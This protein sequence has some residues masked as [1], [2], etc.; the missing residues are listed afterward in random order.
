MLKRLL[1]PLGLLLSLVTPI[2]VS[3]AVAAQ[4]TKT[5]PATCNNFYQGNTPP[6]AVSAAVPDRVILCE[7]FYATAYSTRLHN[8]IW[9]SY[10]LTKA[11]SLG[12]DDFKRC[13]SSFRPDPQLT[14]DQQGNDNDYAHTNFDR[15]HLVPADDAETRDDQTH[16]FIVTNITPQPHKFNDG[17]WG[18]LEASL[19]MLVRDVDV[20]FV[21][22]G[23]VFRANPPTMTSTVRPR[24]SGDPSRI[25]IPDFT[26][27]AIFIPSRNIAIGYLMTNA[28][29]SRCT[30]HS[31][32]D[33][34][35]RTGVDPFPALPASLKA[36]RP[37]LNL[38]DPPGAH[39]PD[40]HPAS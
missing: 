14:P 13:C 27:K 21:V 4:P 39:I 11:M 15:G 36:A 7:R 25:A 6:A 12:A 30:V 17:I 32:A 31:I 34:T 10:R 28:E 1:L 24:R 26:Y 16:T 38:P 35:R 8:P 9:T 33:L 23:T 37:T 29:V 20:I 18:D 2:L 3:Q 40:C 19:H 22:T 5:A